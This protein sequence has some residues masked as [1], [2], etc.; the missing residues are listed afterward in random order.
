M[1]RTG[2]NMDCD[3]VC[4]SV[5]V[6]WAHPSI[7]ANMVRLFDERSLRATFF[8]THAGVSVPGHERAL[9]PNFRRQG[10]TMRQFR[11]TLGTHSED[12]NDARVYEFVIRTT[13]GFCPEAIGTRSHSLFYDAQLLT[14]YN[15]CRLEYDSSY[16]IPGM[17]GLQPALLGYDVLE[18]PIYYM[19]HHDLIVGRTDFRVDRL[20]L[21]RPGLKVFDFHPNLVF[22]NAASEGD[23]IRTKS[24][25]HDHDS[26][27]R[28]KIC[29]RGV[30]TLFEELLDYLASRRIPTATLG[31]VNREWRKE[32]DGLCRGLTVRNGGRTPRAEA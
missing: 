14:V 10:D 8:C 3:L 18:I 21:G 5:D 20:G 31:E 16:F 6:E 29:G 30:G 7:V 19:D 15:G 25:Y 26:L 12:E 13:K 23:Y 27:T 1:M 11:E 28:A 32:R 2:A 4:L 24:I 9:H 22:I 17:R